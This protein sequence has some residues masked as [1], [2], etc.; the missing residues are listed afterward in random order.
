MLTLTATPESLQ[1]VNQLAAFFESLNKPT[2]SMHETMGDIVRLLFEMRFDNEGGPSTPWA[3]LEL[4]TQ[5]E[6]K[7]HGFDPFHPILQRTGSYKRSF[8]TRGAG[9]IDRLITRPEGWTLE[10]G[11]NDFRVDEL[12]GGVRANLEARPVTLLEDSEESY[13]GE[14]LD[15]MFGQMADEL[16]MMG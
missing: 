2:V 6:R 16:A 12:E 13:I 10:F 3:G 4:W 7:W 14:A 9:N 8:T 15:E 5:H 11:S 1:D